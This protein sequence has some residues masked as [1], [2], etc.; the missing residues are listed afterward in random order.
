PPSG[1]MPVQKV[2]NQVAVCASNSVVSPPIVIAEELGADV[3]ADKLD[4]AA[5]EEAALDEAVGEEMGLEDAALVA[6]AVVLPAVSLDELQAA[7]R[8]VAATMPAT[9]DARFMAEIS[10]GLPSS[11]HPNVLLPVQIHRST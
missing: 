1:P 5:V 3:L 8:T 4:A 2:S 7:N 11:G 9:I 6:A 10:Y